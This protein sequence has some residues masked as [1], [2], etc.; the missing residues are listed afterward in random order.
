MDCRLH[1]ITQEVMA[2]YRSRL[3]IISGWLLGNHDGAFVLVDIVSLWFPLQLGVRL[4]S[5]LSRCY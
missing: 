5:R 3:E 2:E 4:E 1:H